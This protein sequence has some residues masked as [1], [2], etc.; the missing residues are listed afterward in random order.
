MLDPVQS[1]QDL[2]WHTG[3]E[4]IGAPVPGERVRRDFLEVTGILERSV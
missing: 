1:A 3:A 4:T 2:R